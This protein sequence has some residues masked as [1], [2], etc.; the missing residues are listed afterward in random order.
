MRTWI[1]TCSCSD[2]AL[3]KE[4]RQRVE[5]LAATL[6]TEANNSPHS[7]NDQRNAFYLLALASL[8]CGAYALGLRSAEE[9]HA[10]TQDAPLYMTTY[11]YLLGE[12]RAGQGRSEEAEAAWRQAVA[13][14]L[15]TP[16]THRAHARLEAIS[17]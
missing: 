8:G 7:R 5:K 15:E 16:H 13:V 10:R 3:S 11:Y 12:C 6:E 14:G 9:Y 4:V 17:G 2:P 1:D